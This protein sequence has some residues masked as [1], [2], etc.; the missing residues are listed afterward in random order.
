MGKCIGCDKTTD[1]KERLL[2]EP[3]CAQCLT[4]WHALT[5]AIGDEL[6]PDV[7]PNTNERKS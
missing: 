6:R 3:I 4:N 1:S 5:D 7:P 2:N